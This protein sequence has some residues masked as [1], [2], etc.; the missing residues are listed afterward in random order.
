MKTTKYELLCHVKECNHPYTHV[1]SGHICGHCYKTGHGQCECENNDMIISLEKFYSE[2]M[3]IQMYCSVSGCTSYKQ[4]SV[5]SHICSYCN[6]RHIES[7]CKGKLT[8]KSNGN[9]LFVEYQFDDKEFLLS[10]K[11]IDTAKNIF[12]DKD[13]KIYSIIYG[14]MGCAW[15]MKRNCIKGEIYGYFMHS[16]SWGQYGKE[17]DDTHG[18]Y[19]FLYGY[20][21]IKSQ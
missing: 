16:D 1:T 13:G 3:P 11:F 14:G 4:H 18:L 20:T 7:I 17:C 9:L 21:V 10:Y 12:G 5:E 2:T 6:T 19:R 8:G 15:Y